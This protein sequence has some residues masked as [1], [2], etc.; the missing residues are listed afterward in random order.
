MNVK[1]TMVAASSCIAS[2]GKDHLNVAARKASSYEAMEMAVQRF[3]KDPV[4]R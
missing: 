3:C 1:S 2:I 4:G